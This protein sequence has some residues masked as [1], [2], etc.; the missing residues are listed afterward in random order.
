[1]RRLS[2]P[3]HP[4]SSRKTGPAP[5]PKWASLNDTASV[6]TQAQTQNLQYHSLVKKRPP[7]NEHQ[8]PTFGP[9][10]WIGSKFTHMSAHHGVSF[11]WLIEYTN[12]VLR[13]TVFIAMH[14]WG[15]KL[16]IILTKGYYYLLQSCFGKSDVDETTVNAVDPSHPKKHIPNCRH[17]NY[18]VSFNLVWS[19]PVVDT[20]Q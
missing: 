7:L 5:T 15:K 3:L 19:N 4:T 12:G 14:I 6:G 2:L 16:R 9:I 20:P 8:P 1:M 13:S 11:A 18:S 10:S 17:N